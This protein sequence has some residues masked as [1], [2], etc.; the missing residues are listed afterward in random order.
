MFSYSLTY[1]K[2]ETVNPAGRWGI[3]SEVPQNCGAFRRVFEGKLTF[4]GRDY[5]FLK[6]VEKED[7]YAEILINIKEDGV[8]FWS[9]AFSIAICE[10]SHN[11]GYYRVTPYVKDKYTNILQN[12]EEEVNIFAEGLP[13]FPF[14]IEGIAN[15]E[16]V[17]VS[18]P[19]HQYK[20]GGLFLYLNQQRIFRNIFNRVS[21]V[22]RWWNYNYINDFDFTA[23]RILTNSKIFSPVTKDGETIYLA[24]PFAGNI[25]ANFPITES[26][27]QWCIIRREV[28]IK[29]SKI[30]ARGVEEITAQIDYTLQR[31]VQITYD[32]DNGQ[33]ISPD[34]E[35]ELTADNEKWS[36]EASEQ[37]EINGRPARKWYMKAPFFIENYYQRW[38]YGFSTNK[39]ADHCFLP[40][41]QTFYNKTILVNDILK[42]FALRYNYSDYI[43]PFFDAFDYKYLILALNQ[44]LCK[45]VEIKPEQ[46]TLKK[47]LTSLCE[48]F[49]MEWDIVNNRLSVFEISERLEETDLNTP[50]NSKY[51][52]N[53][54]DYTYN[55][56]LQ[57]R[58]EFLN[59]DDSPDID[60]KGVAIEYPAITSSG[61]NE[62]NKVDVSVS[63]YK[64]DIQR[65][66]LENKNSGFSLIALEKV[67]KFSVWESRQVT[68]D[69]NGQDITK[70]EVKKIASDIEYAPIT[71][72]SLFQNIP[73]LNEPLTATRMLSERFTAHRPL[74]RGKLNFIDVDFENSGY[75]I[76]QDL[77]IYLDE[78]PERHTKFI[79]RIGRGRI[80]DFKWDL[81]TRMFKIKLQYNEVI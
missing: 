41:I 47:L 10:I 69:V 52:K 31:Y 60:F 77:E 17:V 67:P 49:Q 71:R 68:R 72:K 48:H 32:L 44:D 43:N 8:D 18:I 6:E 12:W 78:F 35:I 26:T 51:I 22:D 63:A 5:I 39:R 11:D 74:K 9:G 61:G 13:T 4:A 81:V 37:V 40:K 54:L 53:R 56:A 45:T 55:G 58:R 57:P 24:F 36:L 46:I 76:E 80:V 75:I 21:G 7:A 2:T 29:S 27:P 50:I 34:G 20:Q 33:W 38:F 14:G 79:S 15:V 64:V 66:I 19:D 16:E 59:C 70:W 30:V 23:R 3:K 62:D 42:F 65:T 73:L 1:K 28:D 25:E